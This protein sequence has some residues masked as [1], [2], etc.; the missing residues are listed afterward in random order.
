MVTALLQ[1]ANS[2]FV[3]PRISF[4]GVAIPTSIINCLKEKSLNPTDLLIGQFDQSIFS[5]GFPSSWIALLCQVHMH[6]RTHAGVSSR[7]KNKQANKQQNYLAVP[8]SLF[9]I[10][11]GNF[12]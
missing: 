11:Q 6:A 12:R 2:G 4:L 8:I 10:H 3:Q 5:I 1:L 9:T 7:N